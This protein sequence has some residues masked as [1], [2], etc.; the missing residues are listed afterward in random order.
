MHAPPPAPSPASAPGRPRAYDLVVLGATGFTG[1]QAA[2]A[3]AAAAPPG[4]RWAIAG[5]SAERLRAVRDRLGMPQLAMR[6][7]DTLDPVAVEALAQDARV[8]LTTV[9]PYRKYGSLLFGACAE[10]GTHLVDITGETV[11]VADMIAAHAA[12]A[13]RT[14]AVIVPFC[15]F[16]SVPSDLGAWMMVQ[17]VRARWGEGT[18]EVRGAF[19]AKGGFNGGTLDTGFTLFERGDHRRLADP[20]L[21][22]P[23]GPRPA[24]PARDRR[25]SARDPELGWVAPFFM[26]PINTR[27]VRRSAA[28]WAA[29]GAPYGADFGYD[30]AM[31]V[32]NRWAG[33]AVEA[34]LG[35][36]AWLNLR[37]W[38]RRLLRRLLPAPG[39]G[40]S[41]AQMDGGGFRLDLV[42]VS[43][44]GRLLR[45]RVTGR[46]DPG[47]RSTV[48]CLVGSALCLTDGVDTMPAAAWGG[49]VLTPAT[50][51]GD[52]L[53]ERLH[54]TGH[55]RFAVDAPEAAGPA[56]AAAR[57]R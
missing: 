31:A 56:D 46:G 11:W 27:V 4:L 2:A 17:A 28:L 3:V 6:V 34:G 16:D 44:S 52:R 45:G 30:E 35:A 54:A 13:Q 50:A 8:V 23:P 29:Q 39:E 15:G 33:A 48:R 26:A 10:A 57:P 41:E 38:G 49:G 55:L 37:P 12:T 25:R 14:G 51:F 32:P 5:R 43:D 40:P 19:R 18:L 20:Y 24:R 22:N 36:W 7:C 53:I 47:N 42:A 1:A 9:G 21:L